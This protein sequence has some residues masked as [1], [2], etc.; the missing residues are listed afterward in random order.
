MAVNKNRFCW[1]TVPES[2][3]Y[4]LH[5]LNSVSVFCQG[6]GWEPVRVVSGIILPGVSPQEAGQP[7]I[8]K[9]AVLLI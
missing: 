1:E 6:V 9:K 3:N 5:P 8:T 2:N 4:P 7:A